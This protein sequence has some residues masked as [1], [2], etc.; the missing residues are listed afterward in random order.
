MTT[1]DPYADVRAANLR[2]L[3]HETNTPARGHDDDGEC[4]RRAKIG[5]D[6]QGEPT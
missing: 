2:V 4:C 5:A 1:E 6:P 3:I